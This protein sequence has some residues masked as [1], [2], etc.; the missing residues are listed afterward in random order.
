MKSLNDSYVLRKKLRRSRLICYFIHSGIASVNDVVIVIL[1]YR[2]RTVLKNI[3]RIYFIVPNH[4]I[5]ISLELLW[6][7]SN[8]T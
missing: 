5:Q 4:I 3:V 2:N 8:I 7:H 1:R 6:D